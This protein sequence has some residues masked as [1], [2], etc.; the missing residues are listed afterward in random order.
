MFKTYNFIL[1]IIY[2]QFKCSYL[3]IRSNNKNISDELLRNNDVFC[4]KQDF[5]K[6]ILYHKKFE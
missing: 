6:S 2:S 3:S 1:F 5:V 4:M